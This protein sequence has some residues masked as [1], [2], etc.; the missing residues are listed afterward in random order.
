[1]RNMS[2]AK[3]SLRTGTRVMVTLGLLGGFGVVGAGCLTRPVVHQEPDTKENFTTTVRQ[4]AVDKIDLLFDIDNS[5]SMGDKQD[6]LKKAIPDLIN[7]LVLPNCVDTMDMMTIHPRDASGACPMGS[8]E[9]FPPVHNMHIGVV[10]SALGMRGGDVCDPTEKIQSGPLMGLNKHNDDQAHLINRATDTETA[11]MDMLPSNFLDWFPSVSANTGVNP[12]SGAVPIT[13]VAKLKQDFSDLIAGV[14]ELGCGIE[15]Q[16]ETWYR[17]LIQPD[18]YDQIVVNGGKAG[19]QGVDTT[20]IKQRHDFLRP[21][22]LVAIIVLSDE[23]DSEIDVRA[24]GGQAFNWMSRGFQPPKA[25][26]ACATNPGDPACTSCAINGNDP[27]CP[28]GTNTSYPMNNNDW[29]YNVNLRHVHMKQKYGVDVQFPITRYVNGLSNTTVPNRDGEY[30]AGKS[31]Y[32]GN[33]NCTNPLFA[34]SLP[35]GSAVDSN[36]LCNLPKGVRTKDLIFYAHIGGVPHEL[37][38]FDPN[39]TK[40]SELSD[41][42]W[43]KILGKDPQH[44]DYSGIDPH[45][46]EDYKPRMGITKPDPE[47][48]YDWKTDSSPSF[49]DRE[50][51]CIFAIPTARNCA[52]ANNPNADI[53][54]CPSTVP[55]DATTIPPVCDPATPTSQIKAKAYPTIR[56]ILLARLMGQQGILSSLC[57]IDVNDNGAGNDP[58]YGYRPAVAVIVDRLKNALANTCLPQ[59]LTADSTG[60]VPCLILGVFPD[61]QP[62]TARAG[63]ANPTDATIAAKFA[64][65][66]VIDTTKQTICQLTQL[67]SAQLVNG[68]CATA[69]NAGWCYVTGTAAGTCPQA[70]L[71][72]PAAQVNG[73]AINLQCIES[74][75]VGNA[76][77]EAGTD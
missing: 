69:T 32:V 25:T 15:S 29:G 55:A 37:L 49:V 28:Q 45:M 9:E 7:R 41:A 5:A 44:Y 40:N 73:V 33:N 10:T 62:C 2:N 76:S 52:G 53:C 50:Y 12:G 30:P 34:S 51:A 42:D 48:G 68:S 46:V 21:D 65:D 59:P 31:N 54:D 14:H 38:H 39:S 19:W 60:N 23:N 18:P 4:Q 63:F 72:S 67:T 75:T 47:N 43:V 27:G 24:L 36:T 64:K 17:F 70:I 58:L 13:D 71:F 35:D 8:K 6:Y 11:E 26:Q 3:P 57:P 20:I 66:N 61:N 77:P 1:M 56:E 16:L 74:N 22:S